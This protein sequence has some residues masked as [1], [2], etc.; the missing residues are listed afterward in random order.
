MELLARDEPEDTV[1]EAHVMR[2]IWVG[3]VLFGGGLFGLGYVIGY[4]TRG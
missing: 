1:W 2:W 4:Y 3:L